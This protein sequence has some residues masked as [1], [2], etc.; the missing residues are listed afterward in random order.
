MILNMAIL[1][2]SDYKKIRHIKSKRAMINARRRW[3]EYENY[4]LRTGFRKGKD[5]WVLKNL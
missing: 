5:T 3:K 1:N 4:K 2:F